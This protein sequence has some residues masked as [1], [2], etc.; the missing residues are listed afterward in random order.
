MME[1]K[2]IQ[3]KVLDVQGIGDLRIGKYVAAEQNFSKQLAPLLEMQTERNIRIHKGGAYHNLGISLLF[4]GKTDEALKALVFAYIEDLILSKDAIETDL[5]PAS[6]V[7]RGLCG[8]AW[9]DL[10]PIE[11]EVFYA[12][13]QVQIFSPEE[14]INI[15]PEI[16]S[17]QNNYRKHLR[18]TWQ[19]EINGQK[20]LENRDF[21][22][23]KQNYSEF[24]ETLLPIKQKEKHGFIK[25]TRYTTFQ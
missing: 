21:E 6:S 19:L 11:K 15:R 8:C 25:D 2:D 18:F 22:P 7:L 24:L 12:K 17:I 20:A 9:S 13:K 5:M 14:L 10:E 1:N 23:A 16:E 3:I 4:Q